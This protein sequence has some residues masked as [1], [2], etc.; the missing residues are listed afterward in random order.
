MGIPRTLLDSITE[1][2]QK[3][4]NRISETLK[5]AADQPLISP[6]HSLLSHFPLLHQ[7]RIHR[8][9]Y[10]ATDLFKANESSAVEHALCT[11]ELSKK[12]AELSQAFQDYYVLALGAL[13]HDIGKILIPQEVLGKPGRLNNDERAVVRRHAL[14]GAM[15]VDK[16]GALFARAVPIVLMHHEEWGGG[17]YPQGLLHE[18][19]PIEA[20]IVHL[21]DVISALI[22]TRAYRS[23]L[24]YEEAREAILR[25]QRDR[26]AFDPHLIRYL[27]HLI[28]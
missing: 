6:P 22:V 25:M 14:F 3:K 17:G 12:I 4:I 21:A 15:I 23:K 13:L 9:L 11:W 19:I 16:L 2:E 7:K 18:D 26:Q 5:F 20:R 10:A 28:L 27:D 24:S 8:V 1:D